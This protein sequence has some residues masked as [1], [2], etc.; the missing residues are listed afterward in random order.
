[1]FQKFL[2]FLL[3]FALLAQPALAEVRILSAEPHAEAI[4]YFQRLGIGESD[5]HAGRAI[6]RAELVVFG[7]RAAGIADS[8]LPQNAPTRFADVPAGSWFAPYIGMA[9]RLGM[10]AEYRQAEFGPGELIRRGE[11][12]AL[13]L[14]LAGFGADPAVLDESFDF[15]DLRDSHRQAPLIFTALKL[16]LIESEDEDTFGID[17]TVTRGEA[18]QFFFNVELL[19]QELLNQLSGA[20]PGTF[21]GADKFS[22]IWQQV[23]Q[24][25]L[26]RERL[27][28]ER[29]LDGALQ[30]LLQSLDDPYSVYLPP[31]QSQQLFGSLSGE[32]TGIGAYLEKNEVTGAIFILAP[33]EG[34]PADKAGLQ[35][36][37]EI[38]AVEDERVAGLA[39]DEVSS[40]IRGEAGTPVRLT[41]KRNGVSTDF[42]IIRAK[43]TI[44]TVKLTIQNNIALLRVSQFGESTP[45]EFAAAAKQITAANPAGIV[46]DLRGNPGGF[47]NAAVDM[48]GY[49]L[50]RGSVAVT[51]EGRDGE[52]A[53]SYTTDR[54]PILAGYRLVVLQNKNSASASEIVSAAIQ[55]YGVGTVV[56]DTSFGKGTVQEVNFFLDGSALKLTVARWVSPKR[57]EIN[58]YGITPTIPVADNP[59]T[60]A[61]EQLSRALELISR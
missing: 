55:D 16:G 12:A 58:G 18:A 27:N 13:G 50:P 42:T 14:R 51:S 32:V 43:V 29:Q 26:F 17:K 40:R 52:V 35:P 61:D 10:L 53:Q 37:D 6:T 57:Q 48:L 30:G 3:G 21:P 44:A 45:S 47:L 28:D 46:L 59:D 31:E 56:G 34:G 60:D 24:N 20:Q 33:I 38:F 11:A 49:F 25:Y 39:L 8:Q 15:S 23:N 7:I 19:H 22:A 2:A 1:M 9:D 54:D 4:E 36:G 5:F 41:I